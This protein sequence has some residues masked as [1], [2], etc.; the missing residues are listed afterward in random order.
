MAIENVED[1]ENLLRAKSDFGQLSPVIRTFSPEY[2]WSGNFDWAAQITRT[3]YL[4]QSP[5]AKLDTDLRTDYTL[6][7]LFETAIRRVARG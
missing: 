1:I 7:N 3:Q 6:F 4:E 2:G 5:K